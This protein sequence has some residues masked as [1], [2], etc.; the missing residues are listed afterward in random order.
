MSEKERDSAGSVSLVRKTAAVLRAIAS[1]PRGAGLSELTRATGLNKATCYRILG[2]LEQERLVAIDG[3]SKRYVFG[4]GMFALA[5]SIAVGDS[6]L[7]ELR[8]IL[9][10]LAAVTEET[11]GLDVLVGS[12]VQVTMQVQGP[13]LIGQ[14]GRLAPRI[15]PS[16]TTSTGKVL[17]A[18]DPDPTVIAAAVAQRDVRADGTSVTAEQFDAMLAEVR[19]RGYGTAI[20]ELEVG[21]TAVAAPVRLDGEVVA[22]VWAGG[23]TFRLTKSRV[24]KVA[25][26][27]QEV[28]AEIGSVLALQGAG[29]L[30]DTERRTT[31]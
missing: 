7:V 24:K 16:T 2:E 4:V 10:R 11:T 29:V 25:A 14:A 20:D 28:A 3:E 15:I 18:W 12:R 31:T 21:A 5:E 1:Y 6:V 23:P 9:S 30:A 26:S 13:Q 19:T 17:L 8:A 22:A 27:L